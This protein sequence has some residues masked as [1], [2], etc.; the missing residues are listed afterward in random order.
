MATSSGIYHG[1]L[2]G[3]NSQQSILLQDYV[4]KAGIHKR[5]HE[6]LLS[7]KYPQYYLTALLDRLGASEGIARDTWSWP[8]MDRT[9][10][11]IGVT[12]IAEIVAGATTLTIT[13]DKVDTKGYVIANDILRT[14]AGVLVFVVSTGAAGGFQTIVVKRSDNAAFAAGDI[15]ANEKLGHAFNSFGEASNAP[16][17]RLYLPTEEFNYLTI[18]RR[19]I[20]VSGTELTNKTIL[21]DGKSWYFTQEELETK[22]F[23]LDREILVMFGQKAVDGNRKTSRG[24]FDYVFEEGVVTNFIGE[25]DE[26]SLQD[27]IKLLKKEGMSN[28]ATVLCG[29][30]YLVGIQRAMKPYLL[31]GGV[32]YGSFGAN[33]VGL[34]VQSYKFMGMTIHFTYY[35]LFEDETVL[36]FRGVGSDAKINF[37]NFSLWLDLGK[38][39]VGKKLISLKHKELNGRSRKLV[40]GYE[41]GMANAQGAQGGQVNSGVDAFTG[42]WLSEIGPEVRCANRMGIHKANG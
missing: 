12:S 33:T 15:A 5:E 29:M 26:L 19:S 14:E 20:K 32:S 1:Q 16:E 23:A 17:G 7:Y 21:G 9:R 6:T 42:H 22:E 27:H 40:Y 13:T 31:N 36:P 25:V 10:E 34:D 30:D 37:S 3:G 18:L 8:V 38:D 2:E 41:V 39:S 24:V 28:E 35:Q 11:N 4:F